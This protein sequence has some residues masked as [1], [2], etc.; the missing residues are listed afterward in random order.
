MATLDLSKAKF[1]FSMTD[2]DLVRF[3]AND[4]V[5]TAT[6]WSYLTTGDDDVLVKGEGMTFD[7]AGRPTAGTATAIEI[8]VGNDDP[9]NPELLISGIN[10]A[11][12][13]LDDGPAS[14]WRFLEGD[15]VILG[16]EL[17]KG[18]SGGTFTLFGDGIA[19]RNG[20]AGGRDVFHLGDGFVQAAGDVTDVGSQ[21]AGAPTADYR[22]GADEMLGLFSDRHQSAAGDAF[23]VYAGSRLTGGND[24]IVMRST[25]SGSSAVGDAYNVVGAAGSLARLVGGDDTISTA[26]G[27]T[28]Y[29]DVFTLQSRGFVQGGDDRISGGI[30]NNLIVGDVYRIT[31]AEGEVI[32]GDDVIDGGGGDDTISGDV[33]NAH[34]LVTSITNGADTIRGGVGNDTIYGDSTDNNLNARGVGG[35]DRLYGEDGH[36]KIFGHG[37]DDILD[38]GAGVDEL[39]SGDGDD[40]LSGGAGTDRLIGGN[41]DDQLDGGADGDA[42]YGWG[43]NDTYFVNSVGDLVREEIGSGI[44][45]VWSSVA[46]TSLAANVEHLHFNGVGSF[47][48]IGNE[49]ANTI[50]G[51]AGNDRLEGAGGDDLLTGGAGAD[52][53]IGGDGVDTASYAAAYEGVDARLLG[54]GYA[55]DALGDSFTGVENLVGSAFGDVLFG[56]DQANRLSGGAGADYLEGRGGS[57]VL[58]GGADGDLLVGGLGGDV[59]DFDAVGDSAPG[60]RDIIRADAVGGIAFEGAGVTGGDRIDL[61]GIDARVGAAGN[62]AFGFGG[63]GAGRVSLID[64]GPNTIVRCNVDGDSD[65]EMEIVIE[66]GGILASAYKAGDFVL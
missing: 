57:D 11:V 38:G 16:P 58:A 61:S 34:Y 37:G 20:A 45:T 21:A 50:A 2:P 26:Y 4:G 41:G 39:W 33:Y 30:S 40:W 51:L 43:G 49:Y 42:M 59:F 1:S 12:A 65:F 52:A 27:E 36:D 63:N 14:F 32:G 54:A 3:G 60:A 64:S 10:A 6:G 47:T 7:A 9:S 29:G 24:S 22:G 19:A 13:T 15:D 48:G 44:D 8:D 53:L 23:A 31:S 28:L 62:Q 55:G 35:N 25:Y 56:D 18:A 46:V 66:D 5:G 17:A